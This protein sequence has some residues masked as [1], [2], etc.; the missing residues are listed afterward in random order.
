M[1][2][3][4]VDLPDAEAG[5]AGGEVVAAKVLLSPSVGLARREVSKQFLSATDLVAY[6]SW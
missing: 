3:S 2:T 6:I 1:Y 4:V 5:D